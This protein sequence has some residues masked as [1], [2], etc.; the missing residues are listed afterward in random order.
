MPGGL[1]AA[2][3]RS[4]IAALRSGTVGGTRFKGI[5]SFYAA[6]PLF[7]TPLLFRCRC[8]Q[9]SRAI[10]LPTLL[11]ASQTGFFSAPCNMRSYLRG[12]CLGLLCASRA[13]NKL[14]ENRDNALF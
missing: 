12:G 10:V 13:L 4:I 2:L 11:S 8:Y 9:A 7:D 5:P 3:M 14:G 6:R 1:G